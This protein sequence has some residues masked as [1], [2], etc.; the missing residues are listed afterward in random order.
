MTRNPQIHGRRSSFSASV[1]LAQLGDDLTNIR[2]EDGLT[3]KDVGRVL[4]KSED[5]ASNYATA[6]AEMP[7]S[8]FLLGCR[9]WNGRFGN[10]VL[11]L[12]GMKLTEIGADTY[13]DGE[14]LSHIL[15]VAHLLAAALGDMETPGTVDDDELREIGS[16]AL[17]EAQRAID[18]MRVRLSRLN[19]R[20]VAA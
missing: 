18:A 6:L 15:R 9:E 12:I 19:G 5:R 2:K 20:E 10:G 1:A 8:S 13:S 7:V 17:D 14:K 4:G 16:E 3:W 11:G